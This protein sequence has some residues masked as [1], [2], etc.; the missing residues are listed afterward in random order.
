MAPMDT[1]AAIAKVLA[2]TLLGHLDILPG[3]DYL[4]PA[5]R[6]HLKAMPMNDKGHDTIRYDETII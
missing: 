4:T 6:N 3:I 1:A 2:D 5:K